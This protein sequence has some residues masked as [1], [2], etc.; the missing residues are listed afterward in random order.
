MKRLCATVAILALSGGLAFAQGGS[1][2]GGAGGGASGGAGGSSGGGAGAASSGSTGS[3]AAS[4][5]AQPSGAGS[6]A[7]PGSQVNG[8]NNAGGPVPG[9]STVQPS[10][11]ATAGRAPG[12]NPAN[13]QD[14]SRRGNPSDRSTSG[15]GN[16]QDMKAFDQGPNN[17]GGPVPR[18]STGQPSA[19]LTGGRAPG[20]NPANPQHAARRGN[21]S[22][23]HEESPKLKAFLDQGTPQI[24]APEKR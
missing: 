14:A 16:P 1:S 9:L 12:V 13:P 19:N 6:S 7:V 3:N 22:E 5:S 18:L 21:P 20:V 8:P 2:G 17:A 24:I 4:Q 10:D 23:S 11:S 15:A